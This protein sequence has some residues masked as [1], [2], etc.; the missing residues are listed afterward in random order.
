MS[1][2]MISRNTACQLI[3]DHVTPLTPAVIPIED[4]LDVVLTEP[5]YSQLDVPP[6]NKSAMDGYAI[7]N[8]ETSMLLRVV[9]TIKAGMPATSI[10]AL[11]T[12]VKIMTG[13]PV[14]EN[15]ARVE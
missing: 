3:R 5:L 4:A 11:G 1:S 13:A 10:I 7:A 6:F 12:T 8:V 2:T 15:T 14:P 9:A